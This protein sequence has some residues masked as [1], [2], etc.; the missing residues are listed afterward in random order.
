MSNVQSVTNAIART[1]IEL[2]GAERAAAIVVDSDG[3]V[4][5]TFDHNATSST[6]FRIASMTKSFTA[7][8]VLSLRD[9]GSVSL[10]TP[11]A[12]AGPELARIVGPGVDPTPITLRHLLTMSS[13]LATDDP[14]ADRHLDAT[15][16][17]LDGWIA[18]G[19]HFAHPTGTAFEY[20]N[21][22][23]ALIGR[24]VH[25]LTGVRLQ[26]HVRERFLK[27]LAMDQTE[28]S[29]DHLTGSDAAQGMHPVGDTHVPEPPL[30][31][32]VIAP[33]GG[34]WSSA[35]DLG[36]WMSFLSSAFSP[37]PVPGEL[38]ASSRREMQQL[39]R[40]TPVRRT[41]A[42]DG[43]LRVAEGGYAMGLTTFA[44]DRLGR[45]VTH[46]GGLPGFG[47]NMRWVPGGV[48]VAICA[49]VTYA[50]M[51]H[52]GAAVL[53]G[54]AVAGLISH[55]TTASSPALVSCAHQLGAL[56]LHWNDSR[57]D[58]LFA[59][60]VAPD[61]PMTLRRAE[62][63][64]RL[65][66]TGSGAVAD[67]RAEGNAAATLAI[68]VDGVSHRVRFELSPIAPARIQKYEWL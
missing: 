46:S 33:M 34:L 28:W 59:D 29:L 30:G 41:M 40:E 11:I 63:E 10:D 49:N 61:K 36:T 23:Y 51:W 13:G 55:P 67:V 17:E 47:S 58:A 19:L 35:T 31:D 45:V 3:T 25:R 60:N 39:A 24:V 27:P 44:H 16:D 57:A 42:N 54:L 15:D 50:P 8:T 65:G 5:A 7:A 32:G 68:V 4:L 48:G 52:A 64:R 12:A 20:S 43:A 21:L 2:C 56:L 14:W 9:E 26:D 62:A 1:H 18:P 53:D 66:L 6:V 22:G 37:T 38:S